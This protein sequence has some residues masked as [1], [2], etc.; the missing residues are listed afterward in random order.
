MRSSR[1]LH[2]NVGG[3]THRGETKLVLIVHHISILRCCL[4]ML[5]LPDELV[6]LQTLTEECFTEA[7]L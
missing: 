4:S 2:K 5:V 3:S 7:M 6:Y 1:D